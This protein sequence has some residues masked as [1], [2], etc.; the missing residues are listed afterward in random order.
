MCY[1]LFV[2]VK[3]VTYEVMDMYLYIYTC[4]C[5]YMYTYVCIY[6]YTYMCV[7]VFIYMHTHIDTHIT[8]NLIIL[9]YTQFKHTELKI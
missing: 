5:I 4:M 7:C 9:K 2:Q 3:M 6:T 8:R 1:I